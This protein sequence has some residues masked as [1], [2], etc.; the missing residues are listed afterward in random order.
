MGAVKAKIRSAGWEVPD[1]TFLITERRTRC[2]LGLD[3]QNKVGIT[4]T[5]TPA[6]KIKSRFDIMLWEQ[7]GPWKEKFYEDFKP[8]FDRKGRSV[9]HVV[10]TTFKYPLC[11]IQ[12]NGRRIR[13]HVQGKVE[14]EIEK[15]L[16]EGHI[17]KLDRCTSDCVIAPIVITVKKDDSIKLALDAKPINRQLYKNKYQMP[18][19]EELLDGVS[20]IVT[21]QTA[22]TLFF[23]VL[24]LKYA[25]SQSKLIP[26]TARQCNFNIVGGKITG[27]YRFLTGF[28][29]LADMPAEF[30]KAMDRTLNNSKNTFFF[31][32]DILIVSKGSELD[33]EKLITYLLMQLDKE[34][35]YLK[36]SK[37]DFFKTEVNW[38][39]HKVSESW[40]TP[41]I[42][43]TEA[44]LK[45]E[46]PKL[47]KQ[48]RS[49]LGSINHLSKFIPNAANFTDNLRPLLREENEKKKLEILKSQ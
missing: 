16:L 40:V 14:E 31:L 6:P 22:G 15:L 43:K 18:N 2:I 46:H 5:Q 19:V 34:N 35:L 41:K 33:H 23:T 39:G 30:K 8:L 42:T 38:L 49:F 20:Q 45:L 7:S 13:I 29:G 4:T 12:E 36:L 9:H 27:T 26:Q 44:I 24:D 25:Y 3:L 37:C 17:Q 21:A 47:L 11:P 28:Y 10:N 48:L 1:A 32:D